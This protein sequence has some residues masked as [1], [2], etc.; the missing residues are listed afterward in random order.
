MTVK[1]TM[2]DGSERVFEGDNTFAVDLDNES[3]IIYQPDGKY[4]ARFT[5]HLIAEYVHSAPNSVNHEGGVEIR[6]TNTQPPRA[7]SWIRAIFC[8]VLASAVFYAG[9]KLGAG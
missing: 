5:S 4:L 6:A 8:V 2:H 1:V 7:P 3:V 9:V